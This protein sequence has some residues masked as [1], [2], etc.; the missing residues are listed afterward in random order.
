MQL[1]SLKVYQGYNIT[2]EEQIITVNIVEGN[3]K[4]IVQYLKLYFRI[5]SI[6][7]YQEQLIALLQDKDCFEVNVTYHNAELSIYLLRYLAVDREKVKELVDKGAAF[8]R[9]GLLKDIIEELKRRNTPVIEL[10]RGLY[11][12]GYGCNL[13]ILGEEY[14]SI[15]NMSNVMLSRDLNAVMD[16]LKESLV[17]LTEGRLLFHEKELETYFNPKEAL[18]FMPADKSMDLR[19]CSTEEACAKKLLHNMLKL[20]AEVYV[21]KGKDIIRVYC[22]HGKVIHQKKDMELFKLCKDIYS[23]FPIEFCYMDFIYEGEYRLLNI[24]SIFHIE[25]KEPFLREALA[26]ACADYLSGVAKTIPMVA[27]SGTNGKTTTARITERLLRAAGYNTGLTSTGGIYLEG[28]KIRSGDTTGYISARELL[29]NPKVEAAVFE[30]ARGGILNRGLAFQSID[31]AIVTS[32]SEDHIGMGGIRDLE[33]LA[34]IKAVLFKAVGEGGVIIIKAQELLL[35]EALKYKK[36]E[37]IILIDL[38]K[39]E[40]LKGHEEKGG[41]ILY[42]REGY[43]VHCKDKK[44]ERLIKI[45]EIPFTHGGLSKGNTMNIMYALMAALKLAP[46]KKELMLGELRSLSCDL[47]T[48]QGRQNILDFGRYKVILD[49]GH[50]SEAFHEVLNIAR[51]M[52]KTALTAIIAAA[53]DRM[54]RYILELGNISAQYC[55]EIIIREQADLRGRSVGESAALLMR[56]AMEGGFPKER[57]SIIYKEEEAII[58]AMK[59]A[60]E[61]E[62]IVLFT[63]CLDVI[64]PAINEYLRSEGKPPIGEGLDFSH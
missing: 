26:A 52:K 8:L 50:N 31:A 27:V 2:E 42:L 16:K 4:E 7:G 20:Y 6:Y 59:K 11:Q 63:Q 18:C 51:E 58:T 29:K 55:D 41:A 10:A 15:E 36:V 32:L 40:M 64:I 24:G 61:G 35:R 19:L 21:F 48:N 45:E 28:E 22:V 13:V 1:T 54:D 34:K 53:G 47:E 57:L 30:T 37:D 62:V 3:E 46:E 39:N 9:G 60:K 25:V 5:C 56:G 12:V 43:V 49:Y 14:Q 23:Y 38:E 17:P 44:E 33:D